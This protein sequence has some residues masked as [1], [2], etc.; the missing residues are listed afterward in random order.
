MALYLGNNKV[1][2]YLDSALRKLNLYSKTPITNGVVLLSAE[3]YIL[4]DLNGLF[5]TAKKEG[6]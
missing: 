3:G 1:K 2:I 5:I 6:E 4:K